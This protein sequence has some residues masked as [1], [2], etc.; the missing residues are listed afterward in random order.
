MP[1][2]TDNG[3]RHVVVCTRGASMPQHCT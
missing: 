1:A 3:Q 2:L